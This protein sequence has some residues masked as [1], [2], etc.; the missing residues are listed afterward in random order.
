M[1]GGGTLN[2]INWPAGKYDL[3]RVLGLLKNNPTYYTKQVKQFF[4]VFFSEVLGSGVQ[5]YRNEPHV[6]VHL[7]KVLWG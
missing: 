4:V 5:V 6:A 1:R 2:A 7:L 3:K